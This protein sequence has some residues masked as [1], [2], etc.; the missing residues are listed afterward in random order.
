MFSGVQS[1]KI[2][3]EFFCQRVM[4]SITPAV[5]LMGRNYNGKQKKPAIVKA[6]KDM[7]L[8]AVYMLFL[9]T[10]KPTFFGNGNNQCIDA[11]F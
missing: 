3:E 10:Q 1:F 11:N 4:R 6:Y 2:H 5:D 8:E 9:R 7:V